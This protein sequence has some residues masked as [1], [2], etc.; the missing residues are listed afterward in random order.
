MKLRALKIAAPVVLLAAVS[1][2]AADFWET[3][4][5]TQWTE[6]ECRELLTKSPWAFS[7]AFGDLPPMM[8]G[9]NQNMPDVRTGGLRGQGQP[10]TFGESQNTIVFEFRLLAAQPIRMA[11]GQLQMLRSPEDRAVEQQVRANIEAPTVKDIVVQ[12]SYRTVPTGSSSV[13]DIHSFFLHANLATFT[14]NTYLEGGSR[15]NIALTGYLPPD[16]NRS[17]PAFLF[18]RFDDAGAPMFTGAEKSL[19]MRSEFTPEIR[20]RRQ[21][22]NIFVR[23]KPK[24]MHFKGALAL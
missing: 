10:T 8:V 16:A 14:T 4:E 7:N 2:F 3:K 6:K 24:D 13:H 20:G 21:K 15:K 9:E 11:L 5:F 22:Y 12:I 23:M 19:T 18:P 1:L 17:N